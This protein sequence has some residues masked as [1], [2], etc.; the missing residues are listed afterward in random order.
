MELE[1]SGKVAL[2]K[3]QRRWPEVRT[4]LMAQALGGLQLMT[5]AKGV[6]EDFDDLH[7]KRLRRF[8]VGPMY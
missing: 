1:D 4:H 6:D 3:D 2:P 8:Q 7:P 5:I